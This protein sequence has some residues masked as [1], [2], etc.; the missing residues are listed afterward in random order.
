MGQARAGA[1]RWVGVLVTAGILG[2][3]GGLPA[4]PSSALTFGPA[5]TTALVIGAPEFDP[6]SSIA[7]WTYGITGAKSTNLGMFATVRLPAG[8]VVSSV[9]A[10]GCDF[11][12]TH[13]M[14]FQLLRSP[15]PAG[16]FVAMTAN[17]VGTGVAAIP[18]CGVFSVSPLPAVSPL[19]IDNVNFTYR[20]FVST[21]G[22]TALHAVRVYYTLQVSPAPGTATFGDV[23]TSHPFFQF[24]EALVASGITVGCG[25]GN[26][27]PDAPLTR[28]QMAVFLSKALGLHFAP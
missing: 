23:P 9:E 21:G 19:V 10:E 7:T 3:P 12:A 13:E 24:V 6:V 25:G 18:G 20:M 28:G 5:N 27:C 1:W 8:A 16:A 17:G 2:L 11:D 22:I 15:V 14:T 26:Y 4:E